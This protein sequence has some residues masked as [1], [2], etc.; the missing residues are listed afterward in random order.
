[1]ILAVSTPKREK[2]L[3]KSTRSNRTPALPST[4]HDVALL[5]RAR[6]RGWIA[7]SQVSV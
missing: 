4:A 6:H 7:W 5:R 3:G 2:Y 1:M